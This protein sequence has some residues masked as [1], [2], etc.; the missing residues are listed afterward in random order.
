MH[1]FIDKL[2][3]VFLVTEKYYLNLSQVA[4]Q[5]TAHNEKLLSNKQQQKRQNF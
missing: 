5:N 4:Q 2:N 3:F 1:Q